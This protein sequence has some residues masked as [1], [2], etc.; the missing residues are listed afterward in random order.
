[1][2]GAAAQINAG[3]VISSGSYIAPGTVVESGTEIPGG[4]S[5]WV[6]RPA[7]ALREIEIEERENW[8]EQLDELI[9]LGIVHNE[10]ASKNLR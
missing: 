9:K 3:A 10:Y 4:D 1:M 2:I 6:G 5:V 7:R 8:Q